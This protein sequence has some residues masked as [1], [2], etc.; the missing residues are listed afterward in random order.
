[1]VFQS[2]NTLL[3]FVDYV[4]GLQGVLLLAN[5]SYL[6]LYPDAAAS[7]PSLL[8]GAT[9]AVVHTLIL[10]SLALGLLF[11]QAVYQRNRGPMLLSLPGRVLAVYFFWT[12]GEATRP[13][14]IYEGTMGVL[15][16]LGLILEQR[17]MR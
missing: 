16:A 15:T 1:M 14:A 17:A 10:T 3:T 9:P 6:F 5:C 13:V 8:E 7:L 4:F 12:D 11:L 2:R